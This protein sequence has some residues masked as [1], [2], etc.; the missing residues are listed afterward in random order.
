MWDM[1]FLPIFDSDLKQEIAGHA[2]AELAVRPDD[3]ISLDWVVGRVLTAHSRSG[4]RFRG[5]LIDPSWHGVCAVAG[6][7]HLILDVLTDEWW[8]GEL[9]TAY[10]VTRDGEETIVPSLQLT[11]DEL[12]V[13]EDEDRKLEEECRAEFEEF[14][15]ERA[16]RK[17]EG[18]EI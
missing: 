6:M 11:V 14:L 8:P 7:K 17:A 16:R 3:S 9:Q 13:I 1:P 15:K 4:T 2:E 12:R 5:P 10:V 18:R